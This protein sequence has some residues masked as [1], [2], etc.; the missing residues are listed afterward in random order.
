MSQ[1]LVIDSLAFA[2][3]AG[4]LHGELPIADLARVLDCLT[5]S[6]GQLL[7]RVEGSVS[8]KNSSREQAQLLVQ[9]DGVLSLR[10][11]RCL[12]GIDHPLKLRSVLEL[13]DSE[14]ALTQDEL[15]DDSRDFLPVQKELDLAALI[16]DEIILSLPVVPRHDACSMPQV[17][18]Q[19][20]TETTAKILPFA[21]ALS[22][23]KGEV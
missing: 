14:E 20:T 23:L 17:G 18:R 2:R 10:C 9:V 8:D 6:T 12:E 5:S 15:E 7:Y 3:Q 13:I 16:E 11:Q 22:R 21:A 19:A 4:V 1:R